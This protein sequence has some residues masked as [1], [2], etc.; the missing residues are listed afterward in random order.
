M[1][2]AGPVHCSRAPA[3]AGT[4]VD[5][6]GLAKHFGERLPECPREDVAAATR[7][8]SDAESESR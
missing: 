7:G 4:V 8:E 2:Q 5:C 3:R 1:P 6:D